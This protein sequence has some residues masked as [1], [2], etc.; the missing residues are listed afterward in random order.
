MFFES[1]YVSTSSKQYALDQST[2]DAFCP[3]VIVIGVGGISLLQTADVAGTR[4]NHMI[5]FLY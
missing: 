4:S 5:L 2:D 3:I 1:G